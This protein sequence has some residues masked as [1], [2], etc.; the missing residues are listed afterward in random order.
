MCVYVCGYVGRRHKGE[1]KLEELV[2]LVVKSRV[3][4]RIKD[5]DEVRISGDFS[6]LQYTRGFALHADAGGA[7]F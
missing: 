2:M 5:V 7:F 4:E 6:G 1:R 3:N